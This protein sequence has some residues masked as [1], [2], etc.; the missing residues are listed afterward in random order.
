MNHFGGKMKIIKANSAVFYHE[1]RILLVQ[2]SK[3]DICPLMW[4]FPGGGQD[5]GEEDRYAAVRREIR[6]EIGVPEDISLITLTEFNITQEGYRGKKYDV[7]YFIFDGQNFQDY[8]FKLDGKEIIGIAWLTRYEAD[9]LNLTPWMPKA[10]ERTMLRLLT[11][12]SQE[13]GL[14]DVGK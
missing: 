11:K 8:P 10:I 3:G 7:Q 2:R 13:M 5:D 1:N 9:N 14:Y 6:E 12:E 4:S